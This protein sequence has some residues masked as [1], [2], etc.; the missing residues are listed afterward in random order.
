MT[1]GTG[2]PLPRFP[3]LNNED[4]GV[5]GEDAQENGVDDAIDVQLVQVLGRERVWHQWVGHQDAAGGPVIPT[6]ENEVSGRYAANVVL[7]VRAQLARITIKKSR[8]KSSEN[9]HAA[10]QVFSDQIV[11]QVF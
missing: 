3:R 6:Q 1:I 9:W 5:V 4:V 8:A 10:R 7:Q 2:P 11:G